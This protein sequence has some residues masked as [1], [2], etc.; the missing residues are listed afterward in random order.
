MQTHVLKLQKEFCEAV[1]N[2]DKT[3]ELRFNDRG[4][5]K[6]DRIR[7]VSMDGKERAYHP[8]DNDIY[9]ITYVLSGWGLKDMFVALSIENI[10][11]PSDNTRGDQSE[12]ADDE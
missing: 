7:F 3:F 2:G 1:Y 11:Y 5:Q 9:E 12:E 4:F 8:I 6:G 10:A